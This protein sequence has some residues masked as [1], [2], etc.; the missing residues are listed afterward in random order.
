MLNLK[1]KLFAIMMLMVMICSTLMIPASECK[2]ADGCSHSYYIRNTEHVDQW[3]GY[4][5]FYLL[6]KYEICYYQVDVY[7]AYY[8][9]SICGNYMYTDTEITTIHTNPNCQE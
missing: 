1:K 7:N 5:S 3:T 6:G 9:C 2:A 8:Y 4:H